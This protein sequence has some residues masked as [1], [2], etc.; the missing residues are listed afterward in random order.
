MMYLALG[1]GLFVLLILLEGR[2]QARIYGPPS[3]TG[4]SGMG[5]AMLELQ[6]HLEPEKRTEVLLVE[7]TEEEASESGEPI[8]PDRD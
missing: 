6:K 4:S 1:I 7:P 5:S 3:G 8:A 2:R